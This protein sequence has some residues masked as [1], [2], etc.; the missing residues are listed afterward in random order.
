MSRERH[1]TR[2]REAQGHGPWAFLKVGLVVV[3]LDRERESFELGRLYE[4][5]HKGTRPTSAFVLPNDHHPVMCGRFAL[6][7]N[8]NEYIPVLQRHYPDVQVRGWA[9]QAGPQD[10]PRPR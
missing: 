2:W 8:G 10:P 3:E 9:P 6:A 7:L 1:K 5:T 4:V